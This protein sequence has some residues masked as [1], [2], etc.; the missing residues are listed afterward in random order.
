MRQDRFSGHRLTNRTGKG[1]LLILALIIACALALPGV[2]H[3]QQNQCWTLVN[4]VW[5]FNPA[6]SQTPNAPLKVAVGK[7][8]TVNNT[9]TLSGTD[10][11]ALNIGQGGTLGSAAYASSNQFQPAGGGGNSSCYYGGSLTIGTGADYI[12]ITTSTGL[13]FSSGMWVLCA[14]V[15]NP[16][17]FMYG[18][19]D[20]YN[21]QSGALKITVPASGSTGGSGTYT[22]WNISVAGAIGPT[23]ATGPSGAPI[24]SMFMWGGS[25]A[26]SGYIFA[27]GQC[28][29][30][31]GTYNNLYLAYGTSWNTTN[32]CTGSTFGVPNMQARF[33]IGAGQGATAENGGTG[34]NQVLGTM[35]NGGPGLGGTIYGAETHTQAAGEFPSHTHTAPSHTHQQ[36]INGY[37]AQI[38]SAPGYVIVGNGG[39]TTGFSGGAATSGPS[40]GAGGASETTTP[41]NFTTASPMNIMP[42]FA[43]VNYIIRY[44]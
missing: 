13:S 5:T 26:P 16:T 33:P 25:T 12:N 37:S 36:S 21:A 39:G 32:G 42:P 38:Y 18:Y 29:A 43:V 27:Q 28:L 22:G 40:T 24:G 19:V 10:N 1:L 9:L 7:Q 41:N 8:L 20:T 15:S 4:G 14:Y 31:S 6:C 30:Q 11:A 3:S 23:G 44:Q 2:S 34:T 35:S 17:Q